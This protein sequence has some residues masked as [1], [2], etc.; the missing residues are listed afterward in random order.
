[1]MRRLCFM[2][3]AL[4]ASCV[5]SD[6]PAPVPIGFMDGRV[7]CCS[8]V[9][10]ATARTDLLCGVF[11]IEHVTNYTRLPGTCARSGEEL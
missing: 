2:L 4:C 6:P 5:Y 1:M 8:I 11:R 3:S 10:D 7:V 9:Y